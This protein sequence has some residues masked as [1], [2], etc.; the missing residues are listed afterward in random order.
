VSNKK[1]LVDRSRSVYYGLFSVLFAFTD[2][3]DRFDGVKETLETIAEYPIT[4][5]AK[6]ATDNLLEM[7]KKGGYQE[8]SDEYD[9]VFFDPS[10]PIRTTASYFDEGYESGKKR[11]EMIDYILK[12]Q[13]RLD[14]KHYTDTEDDIGFICTFM[15]HLI[16]NASK[17]NNYDKLQRDV[18]VNILN[19]FADEF[20]NSLIEYEKSRM[21][22]EIA[23]LFK[24]FIEF[25]R[26]YFDV[27]LPAR[28]QEKEI[29]AEKVLPYTN[30]KHKGRHKAEM[31]PSCGLD[32]EEEEAVEEDV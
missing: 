5:E 16:R 26:M 32:I 21:Y 24:A 12:T 1:E 9:R 11:V 23:I 29:H 18:F 30:L 22:R 15:H 25:E 4:D 8:L 20:A 13:F 19:P 10:S 17:E 14:D 7:L 3:D 31:P 6:I 28:K 27:P 2:R